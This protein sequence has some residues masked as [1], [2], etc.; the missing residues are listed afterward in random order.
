[1]RNRYFICPRFGAPFEFNL[2]DDAAPEQAKITYFTRTFRILEQQYSLDNYLVCF[3]WG[4]NTRLPRL[5]T[6]VIAVIHGDEHCRVPAYASRVAAVIKCHGLFPN[7]VRRLWPIRLAQIEAAEFLRNLVLWLPT[8][9]SWVFSP[10]ARARCHVIPLGY[11]RPA[12]FEPVPFQ[13][14]PYLISFAGSIASEG[15][16]RSLRGLVGTPKAYCRNAMKRVL[17]TL[18]DRYGAESVRLEFT[19][20]FQQSMQGA[21]DSYLEVLGR[22][23]LCIAPRGTA[24]ETL[25]LAE[26]L[27]F[28]CIVITDRLPSHPFYRDSPIIQI[29]DWCD[30][31][32]LI[33]E[34]LA[35]RQRLQRL[36]E[37]SLR[38]WRDV[39]CEQA[40]AA[41]C[42]NALGLSLSAAA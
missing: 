23:K 22:T 10:R 6:D 2:V 28:G 14:R 32:A 1:M 29:E 30:L 21:A 15:S 7:Y 26:G 42:A 9:W 33:D 31:P 18:Q 8:G 11:G 13:Q 41:R 3:A 37:E 17:E 25:R 24:H 38:Y 12:D 4:S 40:L 39:I 34:L 27:R 5:G 16:N 20:G 35:D 36:H 19:G